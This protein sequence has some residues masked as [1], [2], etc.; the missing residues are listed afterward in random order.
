MERPVTPLPLLALLVG[1]SAL[2]VGPW[3]VRLADVGPVASGFWRLALGSAMLFALAAALGARLRPPPR[4]LTILLLLAAFFFAA[5]LA[6]WHQGILLTKMG[7]SVLF[8]NFGSFAFACYGLLL[9]RTWP[10]PAQV[11]ALLLAAAGSLLLL[12]GSLDLGPATFWGDILCL[13]AGLLYAGYLIAVDRARPALAPLPLLAWVSLFGA[14]MLLPLAAAT[15]AT[16]V[17]VDWGPVLLL[18]LSS[19]VVG[20]G[21]LVYAI[22]RLPPLVVGLGL[23]TQPAVAGVT[24]W[25]VYGEIFTPRDW[26]GAVMI[27][28]ALVLVRLRPRIAAAT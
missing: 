10:R 26:A 12:S 21:L 9:A 17:P 28:A 14:L 24:G 1:A 6:A 11:G 8:G 2:A 23:L 4:P 22:G 20:Q 7:N 19:Q 25:L 16:L 18:A 27:G 3:F 15:P 5:D 13:T